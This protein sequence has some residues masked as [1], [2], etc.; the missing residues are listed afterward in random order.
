MN[1]NSEHSV[2]RVTVEVSGG[3]IQDVCADGDVYVLAIDYDS[4]KEDPD[5]MPSIYEPGEMQQVC[6]DHVQDLFEKY[7]DIDYDEC[8][9]EEFDVI[10]AELVGKMSAKQILSYGDVNAELREELN[11]QVLDV[12]ARRRRGEQV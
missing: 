12:W 10:L 4:M 8:T 11:N 2:P 7:V 6:I 3:L 5:Y 9:D 1:L